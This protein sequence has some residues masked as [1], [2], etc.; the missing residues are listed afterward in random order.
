MKILFLSGW[1]PYPPINGA[2]IRIHNLIR[3]LAI[4]H[5]VSLL[6]FVKT[7]SISEAQASIPLLKK[8]CNTV[9]II[10]P[11]PYDPRSQSAF[12]GYFS[13][14]PRSLYQTY[15]PETNLRINSMINSGA[16]DVVIAS[17]VNAPSLPSVHASRVTGVPVILD[18]LEVGLEKGDYL[19]AQGVGQRVRRGLTWWKVKRLTREVLAKSTA[20]TV[21]SAI[22]KGNISE[23][24]PD[25]KRIEIVPHSLDLSHY[26]GQFGTPLKGSLVFTGSFAYRANQDAACYF[27][28]KIFPKIRAEHSHASLKVVG[29]TNGVDLETWSADDGITFTGLLRDVRPAIAQ[30]WVSVVPLRMG[31]GTRLKIIESMALGT[32][33]VSTSKGAEGLPVTHGE[34]ILIADSADDFAKATLELLCD[35]G[36]RQRLA[37]AG[38][39]FVQSHYSSEVIGHQYNRFLERT[40]A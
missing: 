16:Y 23:I 25:F 2:K 30:S 35:H 32:P 28:D 34:N 9:E 17:E 22:E 27:I 20:C 33:V 39:E 15:D 36:F 12:R 21:P 19:S 29:S 10:S 14:L 40:L 13:A 18:A 38:I 1:Y 24:S 11:K 4:Q 8:H 31:A 5:E 37:R 3:Q 7:I 6:S 26:A